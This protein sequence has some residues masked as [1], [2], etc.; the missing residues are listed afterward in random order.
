MQP[1]LFEFAPEL[2]AG[3]RY[4]PEFLE[5]GEESALLE[6]IAR[7]EF[8]QFRWHEFTGKRRTVTF[9]WSYSFD[10]G[11]ISVAN[12]FPPFLEPL[13]DRASEWAGVDA[14]SLVQGLVTEYQPGAGIG[15]HRDAPPFGVIVG[16]SL[17]SDCRFRLRHEEQKLQRELVVERRSIYA[18]TGE[19][20][21]VWQH[22]IPPAAETRYSITFRTLRHG[23]T[24]KSPKS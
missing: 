6:E 1:S 10:K 4:Q 24:R 19:A 3:L 15:W 13:Q 5:P 20:R 9:G 21:A 22:G 14:G 7:L 12:P 17:A 23:N 2:P 16:I 11:E 18:L 8:R